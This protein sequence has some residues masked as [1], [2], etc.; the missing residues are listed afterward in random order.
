MLAI[1]STKGELFTLK[2]PKASLDELKSENVS[3]DM[4]RA[5][6]SKRLNVEEKYLNV[7]PIAVLKA[8]VSDAD[9]KESGND[10]DDDSV[11]TASVYHVP[12]MVDIVRLGQTFNQADLFKI[13]YGATFF[14]SGGGGSMRSA[15][16]MAGTITGTVTM[17][18]PTSPAM[19]DKGCICSGSIGIPRAMAEDD[20]EKT[21][22][23]V[24]N[25]AN[26]ADKMCADKV[27]DKFEIGGY[28]A[29]EIGACNTLIPFVAASQTNRFVIDMDLTGRSAPDIVISHAV[30]PI[31]PV[32]ACL[33][34]PSTKKIAD[35]H[36]IFWRDP[37]LP[38]EDLNSNIGGVIEASGG[39]ISAVCLFPIK[40]PSDPS[41]YDTMNVGTID[42][43][44]SVGNAFLTVDPASR[45]VEV[46][47]ILKS[48]DLE[49]YCMFRGTVQMC[50]SV[51]VGT[52]ALTA[53]VYENTDGERLVTFG[54][55]ETLIAWNESTKEY[56]AMGPDL[57]TP[58]DC[59]YS[60]L[61]TSTLEDAVKNESMKGSEKKVYHVVGTQAWPKLR[62]EMSVAAWL[63]SIN[64]L[65]YAVRNYEFNTPSGSSIKFDLAEI[66]EYIPI[67]KLPGNTPVLQGNAPVLGAVSNFG[68]MKNA[69]CNTWWN[70][71]CGNVW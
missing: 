5:L 22:S 17:F 47:R 36:P 7:Y 52:L 35:G 71:D 25:A 34:W 15:L 6:L 65:V 10:S 59:N 49:M 44:H 67:E 26:F 19:P 14:G 3:S 45:L 60:P 62:A 56:Q 39:A 2:V 54:L 33:A 8:D 20:A 29:G 23:A 30:C 9:E 40:K 69:P 18:S 46:A 63:A 57:I 42:L 66:K 68:I 43:A 12:F 32:P 48:K 61:D 11:K 13:V 16:Q 70:I 50:V 24:L 21:L 41:V 37:K 1:R 55:N 27:D 53:T 4:I 31:V 64:K 51:D 58:L 38:V 28:Y